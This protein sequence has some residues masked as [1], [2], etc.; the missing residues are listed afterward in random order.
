MPRRKKV[1]FEA[2][3]EDIGEKL[4]DKP[5]KLRRQKAQKKEPKPEVVEEKKEIQEIGSK[6]EVWE[7]MALKTKRGY[8]KEDLMKNDKG[9]IILKPKP[10]EVK[11]KKPKE[12]KLTKKE[13]EIKDFEDLTIPQHIELLKKLVVEYD[14]ENKKL[15]EFY[16]LDE[17]NK[18]QEKQVKELQQKTRNIRDLMLKHRNRM[19]E[20]SPELYTK[21]QEKERE[22]A[23]KKREEFKKSKEYKKQKAKEEKERKAREEEEKL[24][25][26][27]TQSMQ[28]TIKKK[29]TKKQDRLLEF[30]G[31][32]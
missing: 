10:K 8:T 24:F 27:A 30:F 9:S 23:K 3:I 28:K 32:K 26:E 4:P 17:F 1:C 14:K 25:E 2:T 6:Q 29:P 19:K 22:E 12:K 13:Q 21:F 16:E 20:I 7:G 31:K 11:E 5:P 15:D 18:F